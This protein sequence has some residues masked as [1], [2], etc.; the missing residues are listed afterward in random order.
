MNKPIITLIVSCFVTLPCPAQLAFDSYILDSDVDSNYANPITA[1]AVT[2]AGI[3]HAAYI[4]TKKAEVRYLTGIP[5]GTW[6]REVIPYEKANTPKTPPPLNIDLAVDKTGAPWV[7]FEKYDPPALVSAKR[8]GANQWQVESIPDA[9]LDYGAP[10]IAFDSNGACHVLV[11]EGTVPTIRLFQKKASGWS[12][13]IIDQK[14]R[15]PS[16]TMIGD[17]AVI[18]LGQFLNNTTNVSE[19]M[20]V[21]GGATTKL[22]SDP[23]F[24]NSGSELTVDSQGFLHGV[25]SS[26]GLKEIKYYTNRNGSWEMQILRKSPD[27]TF[28]DFSITAGKDGRVHIVYEAGGNIHCLTSPLEHG[29][30]WTHSAVGYGQKPRA[31]CGPDGRLYIFH[32][33]TAYT[34]T[35][36]LTVEKK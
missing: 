25:A 17:T 27:T 5:G 18:M 2:D 23:S 29:G 10:Q 3:I 7:V 24:A 30:A 9:S 31:A 22:L 8:V 19:F 26:Q 21:T 33:G 28:F 15:Y 4:D 32:F 20:Q 11:Y 35:V 34:K 12:R 6:P 14:S 1:L 16:F 36:C 13:S